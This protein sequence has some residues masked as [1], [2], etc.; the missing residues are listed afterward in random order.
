MHRKFEAGFV[1]SLLRY[2]FADSFRLRRVGMGRLIMLVAMGIVGLAYLARLYAS[3]F[4]QLGGEDPAFGFVL[5]AIVGLQGLLFYLGFTWLMATLHWHREL[6]ALLTLPISESI[7][8]TALF[9]PVLARA[10]ILE[11][12]LIGPALAALSRFRNLLS[13]EWLQVMGTLVLFPPLE[14]GVAQ[15]LLMFLFARGAGGRRVWAAAVSGSILLL[16]AVLVR[17]R[18]GFTTS[19]LWAATASPFFWAGCLGLLILAIWLNG[20]AVRRWWGPGRELLAVGNERTT[21]NQ[22]SQGLNAARA[23]EGLTTGMLIRREWARF[24]SVPAYV[25]NYVATALAATFLLLFLLQRMLSGGIE[26]V[27]HLVGESDF[28]HT[29]A[30]LVIVMVQGLVSSNSLVAFSRDGPEWWTLWMLPLPLVRVVIAKLGANG[31]L[32]LFGVMPALVAIVWFVPLTGPVRPLLFVVAVLSSGLQTGIK[33][34]ID[35]A[36]PVFDWSEPLQPMRSPKRYI[37]Y[38]ANIV[39]IGT[40]AVVAHR[41]QQLLGISVVGFLL[42]FCALELVALCCLITLLVDQA[43]KAESGQTHMLRRLVNL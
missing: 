33:V 42:M 35:A 9:V 12:L 41:L 11:V 39:V 13:T 10:Y 18:A 19:R 8:V 7:V 4:R 29:L 34:T 37:A 26:Q 28:L 40:C 23:R 30:A 32:D 27:T 3:L 43:R 6:D 21:V 22:L 36:W 20:K 38:A 2:T 17:H 15:L 25:T 14:L 5:A 24:F 16:A 1:W 31:L